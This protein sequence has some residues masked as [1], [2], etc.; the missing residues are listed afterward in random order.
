VPYVIVDS[1]DVEPGYGGVFKLIRKRLGL[2]AFGIN[3]VDLPPGAE[4]REHDHADSGQEEVYLVLGGGGTM[5]IDGEEIELKPGRYVFVPATSVR[6]PIA[7]PEGLSWVVAGA[8]PHDW[9][10]D[11]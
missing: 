5:A 10:P 4:G 2:R 7:G 6:K 11:F 1:E 3:Q 8:P 9:E